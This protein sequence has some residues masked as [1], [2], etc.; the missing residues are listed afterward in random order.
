[1]SAEDDVAFIT[2]WSALKA[3]FIY[4]GFFVL[5]IIEVV[6]FH[7]SGVL[8]KPPHPWLTDPSSSLQS[9]VTLLWVNGPFCLSIHPSNHFMNIY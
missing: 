2:F 7:Q 8:L 9:A 3:F 4:S 5:Q 6:V 1:M